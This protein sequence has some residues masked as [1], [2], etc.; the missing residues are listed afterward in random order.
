M[1]SS[2][3]PTADAAASG[4]EQSV[5][6]TPWWASTAAVIAL[7]LT[8]T[9]VLPRL[10]GTAPIAGYAVAVAGITAA[11]VILWQLLGVYRTAR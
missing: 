3:R 8:A 1:E 10:L 2:Q 4:R 6:D 7:F 5:Y 9:V 11:C